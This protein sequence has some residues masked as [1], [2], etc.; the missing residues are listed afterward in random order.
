MNKM[1]EYFKEAVRRI[2]LRPKRMSAYWESFEAAQDPRTQLG[3][4]E[5]L[6]R[7]IYSD[8][9]KQKG[10]KFPSEHDLVILSSKRGFAQ[11][12]KELSGKYKTQGKT[13]Q[14]QEEWFQ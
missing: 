10:A 2:A 8:A 6:T 1:A 3:L 12:K 5:K 9:A 4:S 14:K 11:G 7:R 13:L